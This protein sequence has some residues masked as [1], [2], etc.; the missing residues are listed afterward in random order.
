[1]S[2]T[3]TKHPRKLENMCVAIAN[4]HMK[5]LATYVRKQVKHLQHTSK[6]LAKH[7]KNLKIHV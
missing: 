4:I 7:Q 1:M 6:T 2:E 5:T 3:L